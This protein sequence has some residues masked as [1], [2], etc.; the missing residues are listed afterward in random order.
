M[1]AKSENPFEILMLVLPSLAPTLAALAL[2]SL[3][4]VVSNAYQ[5]GKKIA[6]QA[7]FFLSGLACSFAYLLLKQDQMLQFFS[8]FSKLS[9]DLR[10]A[11]SIAVIAM[12]YFG[13]AMYVGGPVNL[14]TNP[15]INLNSTPTLTLT[16]LQH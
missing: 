14:K 12:A 13:G 8:A 2:T 15:N 7:F 10:L 1:P 5:G 3:I 6:F 16:L 9:D 11:L 4:I